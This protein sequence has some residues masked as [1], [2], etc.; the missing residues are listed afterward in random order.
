MCGIIGYAGERDAAQVALEAL[1]RLSYRGYDSAGICVWADGLAVRR[2]AGKIEVLRQKLKSSPLPRSSTAIGHTRW[3]THGSV[4][5]RNCHPHGTERV[6]IVHNGIIE[7]AAE[8]RRE[9]EEAGY[10]FRSETDTEAAAFLLDRLYRQTGNPGAALRQT[11]EKL[12]GSFALC[13]LF[14][15]RPGEL[16]ALRHESPL[17]VGLAEG[18]NFIGSDIPAFLPYTNRYFRLG[19]GE[20]ARV[21]AKEVQVWDRE[22]KKVEHTVSLAEF[23]APAAS[24]GEYA[25]F[26]RKEIGEES[27]IVRDLLVTY[28]DGEG[29]IRLPLD[30]ERFRRAQRI[31][32][33]GCGTAYHAG[34][35]GKYCAERL[36][37]LHCRCEIASEYRYSPPEIDTRDLIIFLS[38][39]GETADT[40]SCLRSVRDSGAYTLGIVN[41]AGSSIAA[42]VENV[43]YTRAGAE[44]AVASTKAY[45]AQCTLLA[46]LVLKLARERGEIR[47]EEYRAH[48][49]ALRELPERIESV[50]AREER[51]RGAAEKIC[52]A[53]DLF[54]IG[55]GADCAVAAEGS[56]KLK[57]ISYIHSESYPAGELKHGT[58]S[59]I[60]PGVPVVVLFADPR[61]RDKMVGNLREVAARGALTLAIAPETVR[62][63]REA[64]DVFLPFPEYDAFCTPIAEVSIL[65]LLAYHT[66][67]LRGC[68]VDRPRNLAKSVTVE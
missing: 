6:Q 18:E 28:T 2:A 60:V 1:E 31:T 54:F 27:D 46:L 33:I 24:K 23:D 12:R 41:V 36:T 45:T 14:A 50:L 47:E 3:A 57:E 29:N 65:Q 21:T 64:A 56:L 40:L 32:F 25:H 20:Y 5:D 26:M 19:E 13:V 61:L 43:I 44:I 7:N 62:E 53:T 39:S 30:E 22:G 16:Y 48:M 4:N 8:L 34:L 35:Y 38:Q 15:D 52:G 59:L 37:S 58:I 10:T 68:D 11:A 63:A 55:R 67:V 51:I 49:A 66:A 17:L 42:E 9:A